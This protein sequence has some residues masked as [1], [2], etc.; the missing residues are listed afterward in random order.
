MKDNRNIVDTLITI[1]Y[2]LRTAQRI[3]PVL[4]IAGEIIM[5]ALESERKLIGPTVLDDQDLSLCFIAL[6]LIA[7]IGLPIHLDLAAEGVP[8]LDQ[9]AREPHQGFGLPHRRQAVGMD[10]G[11]LPESGPILVEPLTEV[12]RGGEKIMVIDIPDLV[13]GMISSPQWMTLKLFFS[14]PAVAFHSPSQ[15][16]CKAQDVRKNMAIKSAVFIDAEAL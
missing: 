16:I 5:G 10:Q 6:I 15:P 4:N 1:P 13:A 7:D 11:A 12:F 8:V 2:W 3:Q 9:D 14:P